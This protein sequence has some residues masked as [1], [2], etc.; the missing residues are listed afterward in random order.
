MDFLKNVFGTGANIFGAGGNNTDSLIKNGL[1]QQTDVDKAQSQS[2]MKGLLGTAVGY[3]AQPKNQ[4]FGSSIPYIFKGLQQGMDQAQQPFDQLQQNAGQNMKLEKY[5][6]ELAQNKR[7]DANQAR[8]D[9]IRALQDNLFVST[10]GATTST[11]AGNAVINQTGAD[12]STQIGPNMGHLPETT[13]GPATMQMDP[14]VLEQIKFKNPQLYAQYI[15]NQKTEAEIAEMNGPSEIKMAAP[16]REN[17]TQ[18]SWEE[19]QRTG[20]Q[21]V[22][23]PNTEEVKQ[24]IRESKAKTTYEYGDSIGS[25]NMQTTV[26]TNVAGGAEKPLELKMPYSGTSVIPRMYR[27]NVPGKTKLKLDN[28]R[29]KRTSA[30]VT[31][32]SNMRQE[33]KLIRD[34]INGGSLDRITGIMGEFRSYPGGDAANAEALLETIKQKEFLNNYLGI[35]EAGGGFGALSEKE[36]E[37]L[38]RMRANLDQAQSAEQ[39]EEVLRELDSILED[40]ENALYESYAVDYGSYDYKPKPLPEW[41]TSTKTMPGGSGITVTRI[42]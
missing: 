35:K 34:V 20:N 25:E 29:G 10:P 40:T 32:A 26:K 15:G 6:R 2:L 37:R 42:N 3:L 8:A 9:E 4:N 28:E 39:I 17:F 11:N 1:L 22:L 30:L 24:K 23:D 13:T 14:A 41:N 18:P 12:G 27:P 31:G 36:G 19:Y 38:E 5:Q 33:R 16:R 21:A 7:A